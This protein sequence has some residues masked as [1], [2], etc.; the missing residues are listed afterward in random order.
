MWDIAHI[1]CKFRFI[2]YIFLYL[3][4]RGALASIE[5]NEKANFD[6]FLYI[7]FTSR[8]TKRNFQN[9]T[10]EY[11]KQQHQKQSQIETDSSHAQTLFIDRLLKRKMSSAV[12]AAAGN[13]DITRDPKVLPSRFSTELKHIQTKQRFYLQQRESMAKSIWLLNHVQ[14]TK[15]YIWIS[16]SSTIHQYSKE[17][18]FCKSTWRSWDIHS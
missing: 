5:I 1:E 7:K 16:Y 2:N 15:K 4:T 8:S 10:N 3:H 12:A 11:Q 6:Y 13:Q 18:N 17:K 9:V 14:Y